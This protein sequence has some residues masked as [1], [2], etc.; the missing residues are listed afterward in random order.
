MAM[1][2]SYLYVPGHRKDL[3]DKAY[4]SEADAIVLELEDAVAAESK[5][6]A[7]RTVSRFLATA[8]PKPTYVRVNPMG[9]GLI[10]DDLDALGAAPIEGLRL[11]KARSARDV[12]AVGAWLDE[13]G[14]SAQIV[15]LL[16]TAAA[17]EDLSEIARAHIRVASMGLGEQDLAA[18]VGVGEEGLAY[19]RSRLV[20]ASRA[21]GLSPPCQSVFTGLNDPAGL[22][23]SCLEGKRLGFFG[24]SAVH[25]RQLA[26]INAAFTPTHQEVADA[27]EVERRFAEA[28]TRGVGALALADGSFVD[29][30]TVLA[31]RA[32]L[33]F[34]SAHSPD[35]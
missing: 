27:Q 2:R 10:L 24:R 12:Y 15:P 17:V 5:V 26:I 3:I 13:R 35:R 9:S 33:R 11:P 23:K 14:S 16:E 19:A 34:A 8:P 1:H 28:L 32:T 21:A 4:A 18:D 30:A 25:P 20:Y 22:E 29:H 7:R 6:K 31:A